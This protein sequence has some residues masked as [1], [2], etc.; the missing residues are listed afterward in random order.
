[1]GLVQKKIPRSIFQQTFLHLCLAKEQIMH[2]TG[3]RIYCSD[4]LTT[5]RLCV[6]YYMIIIFARIEWHKNNFFVVLCLLT[7]LDHFGDELFLCIV[8]PQ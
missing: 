5:R 2:V 3:K 6:S 4:A 8:K 1:M 7:Y